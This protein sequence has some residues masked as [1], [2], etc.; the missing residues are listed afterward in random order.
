MARRKRRRQSIEHGDY[1]I[2][3][4]SDGRLV[5]GQVVYAIPTI[6][7]P[8]VGLYEPALTSLPSKDAKWTGKRKLI[9]G[10][11]VTPDCFENQTWRI[12]GRD[13]EAIDVALLKALLP[14][15]Q[16]KFVG[17]TIISSGTLA[18]CLEL[19]FRTDRSRSLPARQRQSCRLLL[20]GKPDPELARFGF[21]PSIISARRKT[22][23]KTRS[24]RSA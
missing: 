24:G 22:A 4:L 5:Q 6:G 13:A 3:P 7:A 16:R 23:T 12:Y 1:F 18:D 21:P 15:A 17:L 8:F 9:K 20:A 10:C 14:L 2:V 11:A 19:H